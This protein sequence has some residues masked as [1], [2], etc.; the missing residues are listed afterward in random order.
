MQT[1]SDEAL[2]AAIR[3]GDGAAEREFFDRFYPKVLAWCRW[4]GKGRVDVQDAVADVFEVAWRRIG[5]FRGDAAIATWLYAI[6]RNVVR[7]NAR[8]AW[9]GRLVGLDPQSRDGA[10]SPD[11]ALVLKEN[12]KRVEEVLVTLSEAKREMVMLVDI[13]GFTVEEAARA[14]GVRRSTAGTRLFYGRREFFERY[15]AKF[16]AED[17]A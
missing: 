13:E 9:F 10:P 8:K 14:A 7:G 16:G 2:L 1:M 15:A 11:E 6:T 12:A 4:L 5:E 17:G 3:R